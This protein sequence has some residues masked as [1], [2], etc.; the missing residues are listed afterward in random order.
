MGNWLRGDLYDGRGDDEG[1][2]T[3]R[4]PSAPYGCRAMVG[5]KLSAFYCTGLG[6]RGVELTV[7]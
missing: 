5:E 2:Y 3:L 1:H 6:C 7:G 4:L